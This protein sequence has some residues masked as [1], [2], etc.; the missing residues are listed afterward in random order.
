MNIHPTAIISSESKIDPSVTIGPYA[1]IDGPVTIGPNC[2]LQAHARLLGPLIMGA[3]NIVHSFAV[4]G[5]W[6][7]DRKFKPAAG[8]SSGVIIG[9][10]NLFREGVTIHR[11]TAAGSN[12]IIGSRNF[13]MVNS[14]AGHNCVVGNDIILTNG[15]V[16]GGHAQ[17][18][19]RAIIGA[20]CA[21]HQFVRVGRLAMLSNCAGF[22]V[23][24]P[25]FFL[26]MSTNTVTQ[27]NAVGLR[28]SGMPKESINAI[29]K[30]FQLAFRDAAHR[31]L[32]HAFEALPP[33]VLA[34]PEVQ[35][36]ITFCKQSKRGIARFQ[37]WSDRK[38]GGAD[39][40]NI[41]EE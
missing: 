30:V 26:S 4:L 39:G 2:I 41:A 36:I 6:P 40:E 10:D 25:P 23:D 31:T 18:A 21:I 7:Q 37:P 22:N 12:T 13:F 34:V 16:L 27:L 9:D 33:E 28:R 14:H 17:I 20:H 32:A 29:R 1:V 15:A 35:E 11:G 5:D 24:F 38:V 3:R 19:D 8:A